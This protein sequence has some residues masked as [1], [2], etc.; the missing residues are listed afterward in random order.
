M[1]ELEET[2]IRINT[3][4][5]EPQNT[6]VERHTKHPGFLS[7]VSIAEV[8][9][10]FFVSRRNKCLYRQFKETKLSAVLETRTAA[11]GEPSPSRSKAW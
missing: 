5:S 7:E 1:V 4:Q 8:C 11:G 3:I 9:A 2:R 10:F 6:A